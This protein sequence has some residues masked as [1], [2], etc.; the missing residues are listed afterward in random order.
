MSQYL[1]ISESL[2]QEAD[3]SLSEGNYIQA[4]EKLWGASA[5]LVKAI[6]EK[7]GWKH[8][9][10]AELFKVIRRL[11]E[12]TGDKELSSLFRIANQLHTNFYENCFPLKR[13]FRLPKKL[14]C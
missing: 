13:L 8:D 4:S 2:L 12:E 10:H 14:K 9:G 3:I 7:R 1:E 11:V 5:H 6:A